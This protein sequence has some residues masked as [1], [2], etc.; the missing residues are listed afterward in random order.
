L[1]VKPANAQSTSTTAVP[2][3]SLQLVGPPTTVNTTYSLD[4]NTGRIVPNIGY[5]NPYSSL[6]IIIKNQFYSTSSG[7]LYYNV[8]IKEHN[9]TEWDVVYSDL[10]LYLPA[11]SSNSTY[12]I[13]SLPVETTNG[14]V[15]DAK[16][17][18][19]VMAMLGTFFWTG[20]NTFPF[21]SGYDYTGENSSWSNSQTILVPANIPL[22]PTPAPSSS[23]PL[24]PTET[25]TSTAASSSLISFLLLISTIVIAILLAVIIA[26]LFYIR[27][28][29]RLPS[30]V[31]KDEVNG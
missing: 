24:T 27:K 8:R 29:N 15:L 14:I 26:L 5:T 1:T 25:P 9:A 30:A 21:A 4:P 18:V 31:K 10:F 22:S 16:T 12:T 2:Q 11:Q 23:S 20:H 3:F 6:E 28:Q 7:T 17:D 19:Q 13:I